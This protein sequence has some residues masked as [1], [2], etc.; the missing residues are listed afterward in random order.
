MN[1]MHLYNLLTPVFNDVQTCAS[2]DK[3][4]HKEHVP[5]PIIDSG[6]SRDIAA[7]LTI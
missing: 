4:Q 6:Q 2:M 5:G 3:E 7:N 1:E